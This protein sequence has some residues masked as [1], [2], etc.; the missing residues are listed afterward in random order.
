MPCKGLPPGVGCLPINLGVGD[1]S[2]NARPNRRMIRLPEAMRRFAI[3]P[4]ILGLVMTILAVAAITAPHQT[5]HVMVTGVVLA[6]LAAVVLFLSWA[7]P[8]W[9]LD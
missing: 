3:L 5:P 7:F 1:G 8:R 4:L 2:M 6:V 9:K